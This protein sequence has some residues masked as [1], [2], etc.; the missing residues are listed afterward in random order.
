MYIYGLENPEIIW[1]LLQTYRVKM[2]G[3]HDK[4]VFMFSETGS[5]GPPS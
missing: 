2:I 5:G 4:G 1:N 3:V